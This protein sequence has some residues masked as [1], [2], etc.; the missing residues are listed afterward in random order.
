MDLAPILVAASSSDLQLVQSANTKLE[1]LSKSDPLFLS[2]L[3]SIV[4]GPSASLPPSTLLFGLVRLKN[5]ATNS[6]KWSQFDRSQQEY[7]I[8][9]ILQHLHQNLSPS[10]FISEILGR[11]FRQEWSSGSTWPEE[12]WTAIVQSGAWT[13][14]RLCVKRTAALRLPQRRRVLAAHVSSILPH[15]ISHWINSNSPDLLHT[16]YTC[17]TV[18][19]ATAASEILSANS[20][21]VGELI[22]NGLLRFASPDIKNTKRLAKLLHA[23][24][25]LLPEDLC[26]P[27][28]VSVLET[29][30]TAIENDSTDH[31]TVPWCLALIL[32]L[33][34]ATYHENNLKNHR[35]SPFPTLN[36]Q[37][38]ELVSRWFLSPNNKVPHHSNAVNLLLSLLRSWMP[39]SESEM[40]VLSSDPEACYSSGGACCN[41]KDGSNI[42]FFAGT[43]W[44]TESSVS[45][46]D[47]VPINPETIPSIRQLAESTFC[48]LVMHL[49]SHLVSVLS[50]AVEELMIKGDI[51]MKEVGMR[52]AQFL[53]ET[54][55]SQWCGLV[56]TILTITSTNTPVDPL[57]QGRRMALLVRRALIGTSSTEE[58]QKNCYMTLMHLSW[59]LS[60]PCETRS[61]QIA[62]N[63]AAACSLVWFLENPHFPPDTISSPSDPTLTNILSS[64]A[65]LIKNVEEDE[66]RLLILKY[67]QCVF[68][69][70]NIE[71]NFDSFIHAIQEVWQ[72]G[73]G[74]IALRAGIVDLVATVMRALNSDPISP[75][76]TTAAVQLANL[77]VPSVLVPDLT[78][79]IK[80]GGEG[81][82]DALADSCLRLWHALITGRGASWLPVLESL[83]PLLT[84]ASRGSS[85]GSEEQTLYAR[86]ET[87]DQAKLFF[88][89][90]NGCLRLGASSR[91]L[92]M[93]TEA[94]WCP[95]LRET[96]TTNRMRADVVSTKFSDSVLNVPVDEKS[97]LILEQLRLLLAWCS[98]LIHHKTPFSPSVCGL[99]ILHAQICLLRAPV[100]I[101]DDAAFKCNQLR[102]LL[103][104]QL[105]ASPEKWNFLLQLLTYVEISVSSNHDFG[106]ICLS[107][108]KAN[109]PLANCNPSGCQQCLQAFL[110]RL[111]ARE[112][113]LSNPLHRQCFA[114]AAVFVFKHLA[115][116]EHLHKELSE[117]IVSL[118]VQILF[119]NEDNLTDSSELDAWVAPATLAEPGQLKSILISL[120]GN[121]EAVLSANVDPAMW[122]QF[123]QKLA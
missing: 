87:A 34:S 68:E 46:I 8:S 107:L 61:L 53:I 91:F 5:L 37:A 77:A 66:T 104:A 49:R 63:L 67:L 111:L 76:V 48:L 39:L 56:D 70:A 123:I 117:P 96:M 22:N 6:A 119:E 15:L 57:I 80:L 30:S 69:N 71:S 99:L 43:F 32:N 33:T 65:A 12:L 21:E 31:K 25:Y 24:L 95:L 3:T 4:L 98:Q 10:P 38:R 113:A 55:P 2:K 28:V 73:E 50:P 74:G 90:A 102:L 40:V 112:D 114:L 115:P 103:L 116:S 42:V 58:A 11:I 13:P 92:S 26:T 105:A 121:M 120:L 20:G 82:G 16:I 110:E 85:D 83:M 62:L 97:D 81:D 7:L 101:H 47:F 17:I 14:L 106:E 122:S 35:L 72:I 41:D 44:N 36:R 64:L 1:E 52:A 19:D 108:S 51:A 60:L 78:R 9:A 59:Y 54:E 84:D 118:C 100:E 45:F 94:F 93:W 27:Y 109:S 75:E 86:L 89:I 79:F 18:L 29:M 23:V 88:E